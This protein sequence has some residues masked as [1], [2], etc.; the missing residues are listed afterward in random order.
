MHQRCT[1]YCR[2]QQDFTSLGP[3]GLIFVRSFEEIAVSQ[4]FLASQTTGDLGA[5]APV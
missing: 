5:K 2:V 4:A 3:A 1:L